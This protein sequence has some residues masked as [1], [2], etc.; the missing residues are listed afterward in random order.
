MIS[1]HAEGYEKML[2]KWNEIY[3]NL[4]SWWNLNNLATP[5]K[6]MIKQ[7]FSCIANKSINEY[8]YFGNF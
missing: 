7:E 3:S 6:V 4:W 5:S 8:N 1:K 2:N